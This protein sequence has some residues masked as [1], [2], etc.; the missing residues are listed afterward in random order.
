M[1]KIEKSDISFTGDSTE[2]TVDLTVLCRWYADYLGITTDKLFK[3]MGDALR[4]A[5]EHIDEYEAQS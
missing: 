5:D 3:L 2:L 4:Y 1:I